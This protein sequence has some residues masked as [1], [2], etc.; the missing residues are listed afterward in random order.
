MKK[1]TK[2]ITLLLWLF[3]IAASTQNASATAGAN[4]NQARNGTD[5]I[6]VSPMNWVNGNIGSG[7]GHYKESM[8]APFQCIMTG[9]TAG[10]QVTIVI[11][12]DIRNSSKNAYDYLTHYNR[13]TPH[14]F[15]FHTTPETIDPITGSGLAANTAHTIYPIPVPSSVGSTVTGQP[16][17]S[18]NSL[19][20]TERVMTLYN[21][22]IDT[23]FYVVEGSLT[24]SQSETQ[25]AIRFTPSGATAV[26]L[27]GGHLG[28]RIDWGPNMTTPNS[29]G[30]ISGSPFHMRL[31]SWTLGNIGSTDRSLSGASVG[32]PYNGGLPVE[33]TNFNVNI[34]G[35]TNIVQW[36][37]ATEINNH[38]FTLER[39]AS[40]TDFH[41]LTTV[42]GAGNSSITINYTWV[43]DT[44]L[45][46]ISYYRLI[47]TDFDG[48]QKILGPV[49]VYRND[50]LVSL[51]VL[52]TYPNPFTDDFM[53]TYF[54]AHR[55]VTTIE[56]LDATGRQVWLEKLNPISG[57]NYYH[58]KN[59]SL[60]QGIYFIS[61]SQENLA[62]VTTRIIRK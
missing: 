22:T 44:P 27:W 2:K 55:S 31:V 62:P 12:Y 30:G 19:P 50:P 35:E 38:T 24:A 18:F 34:L 6:P 48:S 11:G 9:L 16:G 54:S 13:I 17:T 21:G 20:D 10:V 29:A 57:I 40:L 23:V 14:I 59:P 41:P 58:F 8:S 51:S 60:P 49:S 26:L 28:S 52:S 36:V 33:L 3:T 47:Q 15:G 4:L 56:I 42:E 1:T 7:Q 39:S 32:P 43:D 53:L 45:G 37:T 5:L 25:M 46:G 61:L